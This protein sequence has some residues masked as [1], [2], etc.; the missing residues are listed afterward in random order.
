[1]ALENKWKSKRCSDYFY[2]VYN[3]ENTK[4]LIEFQRKRLNNKRTNENM[5]EMFPRVCLKFNKTLSSNKYKLMIKFNDLIK[6][7]QSSL[8]Y[9]NRFN[10]KLFSLQEIKCDE[11]YTY[12]NDFLNISTDT[13]IMEQSS[14]NLADYIYVDLNKNNHIYKSYLLEVGFKFYFN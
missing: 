4:N 5:I 14:T 6:T 10:L 12:K 8:F 11:K 13:I 1:V 9:E 2:P 3:F 7:Q